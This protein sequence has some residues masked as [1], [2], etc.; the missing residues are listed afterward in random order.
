[1]GCRVRAVS[2]QR[3]EANAVARA[4]AFLGVEELLDEEFLRTHVVEMLEDTVVFRGDLA[5]S[6]QAQIPG[7]VGGL[8]GPSL[9]LHG[10]GRV[11][12]RK[13]D[14]AP[15]LYSR[16]A[17][18]FWRG[19][20]PSPIEASRRGLKEA[21]KRAGGSLRR[22][23]DRSAAGILRPEGGQ[24]ESFITL[25]RSASVAMQ[26]AGSDC[27]AIYIVRIPQ[28]ALVIDIGRAE[29]AVL[30][31]HWVPQ[32]WVVG[33]LIVGLVPY[34]GLTFPEVPALKMILDRVHVVEELDEAT[35]QR[36]VDR[37]GL[38]AVAPKRPPGPVELGGAIVG[39]DKNGTLK[40]LKKKPQGTKG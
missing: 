37:L 7:L 22:V 10:H 12:E 13:P 39:P 26:F 40:K 21:L 15:G 35:I 3:P 11:P 5:A 23:A 9:R 1:L 34:Q 16:A 18:A 2:A 14:Y 25:T 4:Q 29:Q 19:Q 38:R 32:E 20:A 24:L 33:I 17:W 27:G 30:I 28:G 36:E 8:P 6:V 31:P